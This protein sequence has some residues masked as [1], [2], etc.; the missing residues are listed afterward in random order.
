VLRRSGVLTTALSLKIVTANLDRSLKT[1][2]K[3]PQI[4]RES[5]YYLA[6][7][8]EVKSIDD[9]VNDRRLFGFAMTA[10]GLEDMIYAK[11][12]IK[13]VLAEGID[14]RSSFANQLADA[15]FREFA[16]AFN[17]ARYGGTATVFDRARQGT[18]D[19]FVRIRLEERAGASDEGVRLALYFQRKAA[20]LTSALGILADAA[21][22]KV[23]QTALGIPAASANG[24]ISRQAAQINAKLDIK[25]LK[26]PAYLA[27]FLD[28]FAARW[29][30]AKGID[31]SSLPALLVGN[32]SE[33]TISP[34][35]LLAMQTL[36]NR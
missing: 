4:K 2:A 27:K 3:D 36:R 30:A 18:V 8:G 31:P 28:R 23:A 17:F 15:R 12:L 9:F 5:E 25:K 32:P 1:V 7:I 16:E 29:Q 33:T 24:D 6:H 26:D 13:K 14:S 34:Q 35:A 11:A 19:R 10:F 20:G 22:L 21:L